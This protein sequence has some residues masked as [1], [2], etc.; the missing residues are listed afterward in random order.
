MNKLPLPS[1]ILARL[2]ARGAL[3]GLVLASPALRCPARQR[4]LRP[5]DVYSLKA[6]DDPRLSP[7]GQWVAYTVSTLD[8]KKDET[9]PDIYMAPFAG[10][11]PVR[12]TTAKSETTP[13]F[14]PDGE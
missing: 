3:V 12:L 10:G 7:D 6:V 2:T 4:T 8:A 9:D 5:D 1:S 11:A 13:R 14:S